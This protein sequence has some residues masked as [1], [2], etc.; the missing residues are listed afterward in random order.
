[1]SELNGYSYDL[2]V[3]FGL[4]SFQ[5]SL[6]Q[7]ALGRSA[8]ESGDAAF[9]WL[10]QNT[11]LVPGTSEKSYTA[12]VFHFVF[13]N[14][15]GLPSQDLGSGSLYDCVVGYRIALANH[16]G[17]VGGKSA[18]AF[19]LGLLVAIA[20]GQC[21][22]DNGTWAV[23]L[24][25]AQQALFGAQ[26]YAGPLGVDSWQFVNQDGQDTTVYAQFQE[27]IQYTQNI[28]HTPAE[29]HPVVQSLRIALSSA[30][31]AG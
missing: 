27:G 28:A 2:G 24:G 30:C 15:Y 1:M 18:D 14:G 16:F 7:D 5:Y 17:Q 10:Q 20:E 9:I 11:K 4:A 25:Y 29:A 6:S 3:A 22:V 12:S 23:A 8:L 21:S 31:H 13:S 19:Q 26:N